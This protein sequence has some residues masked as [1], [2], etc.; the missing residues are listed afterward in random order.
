[1]AEG[2]SG[3]KV[4]EEEYYD[5]IKPYEDALK[6]L[7]ARLDVLK[8]NLYGDT[9]RPVHNI[10]HR[11]KKKDSIEEKLRKKEL[12]P[13]L[14]NTMDY[15]QDIAGIRVICYFIEDIYN[16]VQALKRQ[17]DLIIIRESDYISNPKSNGYRS[18]HVIIGI[19]VY[20]LDCME[21]FPV[22]VQ[23]RTMAM[24]L[25]ASMEHRILYKKKREDRTA[26]ADDLKKHAE[27]LWE[28]EMD[29]ER[30]C[31]MGFFEYSAMEA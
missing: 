30:Y 9:Y 14:S 19:P 8:H 22:E 24:D 1:M 7:L 26:I 15:L 2:G 17:T 29:Y 6:I 18:Y 13:T 21:Y 27:L 23:L 11:I 16:L 3:L 20:C 12:K 25:W 5:C 4:T 31:E 10:Q 28:L